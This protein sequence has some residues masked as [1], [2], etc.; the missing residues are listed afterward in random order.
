[1]KNEICVAENALALEGEGGGSVAPGVGD[2]VDF[3]GKGTIARSENGQTYINVTEV[4]GQP[5]MGAESGTKPT[6]GDADLDAEV[7]QMGGG[8][9]GGMLLAL[10]TLFLVLTGAQ[11]ADLQEARGAVFSG[12]AVSNWV[13]VA[14]PTQGWSVEIDNLGGSATLYLLVFDSATNSLAGRAVQFA[15]VPV[16]AGT[17]LGF[18]EWNTGVPMRFGVNV[19][20]STT[21]YSLTNA[22]TGGAATVVHSP[23]N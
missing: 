23:K 20:L 22:T 13:A 3:Q 7:A 16:P 8:G 4:N 18:K 15:P 1:M 12:G 19:C 6:G 10:L 11:A 21:P 9:M 17:S 2:P 14:G 5:T